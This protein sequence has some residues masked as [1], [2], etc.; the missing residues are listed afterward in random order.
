M[1]IIQKKRKRK[2]KKKKQLELPLGPFASKNGRHE[3]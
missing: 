3:L 1:N 2:K